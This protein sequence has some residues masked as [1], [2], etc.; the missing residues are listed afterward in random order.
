MKIRYPIAL[1]AIASIAAAH[2]AAAQDDDIPNVPMTEEEFIEETAEDDEEGSVE[3][4]LDEIQQLMS[5]PDSGIN[6]EYQENLENPQGIFGTDEDEI[7]RIF[8]DRPPFIYYPEGVD[9]MVIP[10]V[11]ERV[12]AKERFAEAEVARQNRDFDK[13]KQIYREIQEQYPDTV[14]GQQAPLAIAAIDELLEEEAKALAAAQRQPEPEQDAEPQIVLPQVPVEPEVTLPQWVRQNTT[15]V[16]V[17]DDG[18]NL[19]IVDNEFLR[20]GDPLPRYA[21]I[22]VE[23]ISPSTVIYNYQNKRFDVPVEG[24]F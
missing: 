11:R 5:L 13:A 20:V 3:F 1:F 22:R 2:P 23:E 19:V 24:T 9:P 18:D 21:L 7:R 17:R 14:E 10:W 4:T 6:K 15:G 12:I 16:L 8:G